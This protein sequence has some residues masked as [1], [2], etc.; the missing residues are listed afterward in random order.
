MPLLVAPGDGL[1]LQGN[2]KREGLLNGHLVT[3]KKIKR[4]GS[5]QLTSGQRIPPDFRL[6]THSYAATSQAAQGRTVDHVYVVMDRHSLIAANA[7]QFYVSVSRGRER[8]KILTDAFETVRR[9]VNRPG[10]RLSAVEMLQAAW[11]HKTE[12]VRVGRTVKV[13]Q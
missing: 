9:A 5:I 2:R 10:T 8:V 4:D 7:K 6:F 3:V 13:T 1:I 11:H 12:Q